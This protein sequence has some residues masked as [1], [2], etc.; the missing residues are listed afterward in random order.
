MQPKGYI[1]LHRQMLSWQWMNHAPTVSVFIYCLLNV[2][3]ENYS[4]W[5]GIVLKVGQFLTSTSKIAIDT[6]LTISQ[7]R[8]ALSHLQQTGEI[9]IVASQGRKSSIITIN[10]WSKFQYQ[11][12]ESQS[13]DSNETVGKQGKKTNDEIVNDNVNDEVTTKSEKSQEKSQTE[14]QEKS[15][16]EQHSEQQSE[17]QSQSQSGEAFDMASLLDLEGLL[18]SEQQSQ[19]QSEQQTE[20]QVESQ[21]SSQEESQTKSQTKKKKRNN[22][23]DEEE[24]EYIFLGDELVY[25]KL[26]QKEYDKLIERFGKPFADKCIEKL[27]YSIGSK[28]YKYKSHYMAILNWVVKEID[29]QY[30]NLK[31]IQEVQSNYV[32][33]S[34]PVVLSFDEEE[35]E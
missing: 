17:Q 6:G 21:V 19:S 24:K 8:T 16:T 23:N 34:A 2:A 14:S 10:N 4:T 1:K 11:Q 30:P 29:K 25:V 26:T 7:V 15:Q 20:S 28:G 27:N 9:S 12:S 22:K 5:D 13:E 31:K 32:Q 3:Y 18:D 33:N 35:V